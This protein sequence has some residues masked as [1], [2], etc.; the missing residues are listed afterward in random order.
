M[1]EK[2]T[3]KELTMAGGAAGGGATAG[4]ATGMTMRGTIAGGVITI[5]WRQTTSHPAAGGATAGGT[6]T[7]GYG[8]T[9]G[10]TSEEAVTKFERVNAGG[11]FIVSICS[12]IKNP[13][14]RLLN[15]ITLAF[16]MV[17]GFERVT[18]PPLRSSLP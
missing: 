5:H 11:A 13:R 8:T 2:Y 6:V 9:A 3:Y 10:R 16:C 12:I 18:F 15:F 17:V 14:P 7:T 1:N 4:D